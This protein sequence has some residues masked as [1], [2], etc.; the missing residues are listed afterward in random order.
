MLSKLYF[1]PGFEPDYNLV[2]SIWKHIEHSPFTLA[3]HPTIVVSS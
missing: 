2:L 1:D 3:W